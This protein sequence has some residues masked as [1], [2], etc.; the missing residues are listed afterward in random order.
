MLG[1][2]LLLK[3]AFNHIQFLF[4]DSLDHDS[5]DGVNTKKWFEANESVKNG[6]LFFSQLAQISFRLRRPIVRNV[7]NK[8]RE[9]QRY[10]I[11]KIMRLEFNQFKAKGLTNH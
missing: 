6:R 1:F 2:A 3:L 4:R 7:S 8:Q 5:H 11:G 10:E 9:Y